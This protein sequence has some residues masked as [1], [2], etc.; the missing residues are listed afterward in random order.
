M[1]KEHRD[2]MVA[3]VPNAFVQTT[4]EPKEKG[5]RIIMKISGQMVDMLVVLD[6]D[7]YGSYVINE[8]NIKVIY[9]TVPIA[10]YGM[11]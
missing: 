1:P 11:L 8:D 3:D 7:K 2:I 6:P 10:L 5:N 9:V 4:I